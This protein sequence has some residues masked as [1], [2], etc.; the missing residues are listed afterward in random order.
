M[1][2]LTY[3]DMILAETSLKSKPRQRIALIVP[4][5]KQEKL[6]MAFLDRI[7]K[8]TLAPDVIIVNNSPEE[9]VIRALSLREQELVVLTMKANFGSAGGYYAGLHY[10][11]AAGYEIFVMADSDTIPISHDLLEKVL[12]ALSTEGISYVMPTNVLFQ[13]VPGLTERLERDGD[14]PANFIGTKR[15]TLTKSGITDPCYF[16]TFEDSDLCLRMKKYGD[17][18]MLKN[19]FYLH[20]LL[21]YDLRCL[22]PF[23]LSRNYFMFFSRQR[24]KKRAVKESVRVNLSNLVSSA[25]SKNLTMVRASFLGLFNFLK[26]TPN[27]VA[28][29]G[30]TNLFAYGSRLHKTSTR[31]SRAHCLSTVQLDKLGLFAVQDFRMVSSLG[32]LARGGVEAY[33]KSW[34]EAATASLNPHVRDVFVSEIDS[35][36]SK[37]VWYSFRVDLRD[38]LVAWAKLVVNLPF[39]IAF[40]PVTILACE[41]FRDH[42]EHDHD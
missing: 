38:K 7:A 39:F 24:E 26:R 40:V 19:V 11:L 27:T 12:D 31:R 22:Y 30:P 13:A 16:Y 18:K 37:P 42:A 23:Y 28:Y 25:I 9:E 29:N 33:V 6:L 17:A 5:F 34:D 21:R 14:F 2:S 1:Q 15:M 10:A 41:L 36:D 4:I 32:L 20:H 35:S 8:Q 3:A